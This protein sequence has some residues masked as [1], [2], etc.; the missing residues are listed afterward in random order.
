MSN[1]AAMTS[2]VSHANGTI[3]PKRVKA[4]DDAKAPAAASKTAAPK[5]K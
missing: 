5:K 1:R 4:L 2:I 3:K